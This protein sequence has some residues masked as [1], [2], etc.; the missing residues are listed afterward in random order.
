MALIG[1]LLLVGASLFY[2]GLR[3]MQDIDHIRYKLEP[4]KDV[5]LDLYCD[6]FDED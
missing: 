6:I 5:S 1:S 4:G 2:R 3:E